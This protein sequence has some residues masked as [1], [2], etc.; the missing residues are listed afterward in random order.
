MVIYENWVFD[1]LRA[2]VI[3]ENWVFDFLRAVVIYE[4]WVFDFLRAVV[5]YENW[6]FEFFF[7]NHGYEF[8]GVGG[9]LLSSTTL[10]PKIKPI[11]NPFEVKIEADK[12]G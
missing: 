10:N 1:F 6:V 4:N 9:K 3:Y 7:E 5:I 2:M 12:L 11:E 8:L